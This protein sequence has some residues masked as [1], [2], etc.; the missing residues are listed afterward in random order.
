LAARESVP[1]TTHPH[2]GQ[3]LSSMQLIQWFVNKRIMWVKQCHKPFF[4]ISIMGLINQWVIQLYLSTIVN[5]IS[6]DW[7]KGTFTGTPHKKGGKIDGF[8]F[9]RFSPLNQS[10]F[11]T[12]PGTRKHTKEVPQIASH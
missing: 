2:F 6:M 12:S 4:V 5:I 7:F 8:R 10:L 1:V 11:G 3:E 9:F